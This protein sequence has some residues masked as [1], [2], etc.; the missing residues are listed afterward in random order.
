M[1][2]LVNSVKY[3]KGI[4]INPSQ[5]SPKTEREGCFQVHFRRST[6]SD[7]KTRQACHRKEN[8]RLISLMNIDVKIFNKILE[9]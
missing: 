1:A 6:V 5:I 4:G 9:N 7:V 8:Y 2:L 3:L